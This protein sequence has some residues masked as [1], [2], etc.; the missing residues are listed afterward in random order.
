MHHACSAVAFHAFQRTLNLSCLHGLR[1]G[2]F[3]MQVPSLFLPECGFC[4]H[5]NPAGA[6]FCNDCGSPLHLKPC[7]QCD[8]VN[9][10]VAKNCYKCGAEFPALSVTREAEPVSPT[11]ETTTAS[12]ALSDMGFERRH[13]PL[14]ESA[15]EGQDVLLFRPGKE[16]AV[17]RDCA[18]EVATRVPSSLGRGMTSLFS[19]AHRA[20]DVVPLHNVGARVGRLLLPRLAPAIVLPAAVLIAVGV[21]V[22]YVYRHQVQLSGSLTAEPPDPA[23]LRGVTALPVNPSGKRATSRDDVNIQGP[24]PSQSDASIAPQLGVSESDQV[25]PVQQLAT[26]AAEVAKAPGVATAT[27]AEPR[28]KTIRAAASRV[29]SAPSAAN[30]STAPSRSR[31]AASLQEAPSDGRVNVT[32]VPLRPGACTEAVAALGLCSLT[33]RSES[34]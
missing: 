3:A 17:A 5:V 26:Q 22:Y 34:K 29:A 1:L 30:P 6:K 12:V 16:S 11:L 4:S 8:G 15:T 33:A 25:A 32:P 9:D 28:R 31:A 27:A 7:N 19:V 18:V 21:S 10:Q 14:F 23:A 24:T 20:A 2:L 13:A